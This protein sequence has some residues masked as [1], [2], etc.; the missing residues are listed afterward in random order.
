MFLCDITYIS[1]I[2]SSPPCWYHQSYCFPSL[3]NTTQKLYSCFR[4]PECK[5]ST[6]SW[7]FPSRISCSALSFLIHLLLLL[8]L[9]GKGSFCCF[10]KNDSQ[11][12]KEKS[13]VRQNSYYFID[14]SLIITKDFHVGCKVNMI[15]VIT[16][17]CNIYSALV[18]SLFWHWEKLLFLW[19]LW[20]YLFS[21]MIL[22]TKSWNHFRGIYHHIIFGLYFIDYRIIIVL[23]KKSSCICKDVLAFIFIVLQDIFW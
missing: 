11:G 10:F 8:I 6:P 4:S 15:I 21:L 12:S 14:I 20:W 7:Y 19:F 13:Y 23:K 18:L 3:H 5:L 1:D 2:L 17:L 16:Y 9:V 22:L